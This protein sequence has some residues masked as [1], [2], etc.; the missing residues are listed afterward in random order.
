M[1]PLEMIRCFL[2]VATTPLV[3]VES[4]ATKLID[5]LAKAGYRIVPVEPT[6]EMIEAARYD[7]LAEDAKGVWSSMLE[8]ADK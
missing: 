4:A 5:D 2:E 1:T 7:A 6:E 3:P 8:A